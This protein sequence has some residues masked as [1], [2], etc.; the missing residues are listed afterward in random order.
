[1]ATE[2]T[3]PQARR[4]RLGLV[5]AGKHGL[6][7]ARHIVEDVPE[8]R[9][10]GL[11]RRDRVEGER[12]AATY[13]CAW[14]DDFRRLVSDPGVDAIVVAVPPTLHAQVVEAACQAGKPLLIEKPLAVN[15]A[16]AR[17]IRDLVA[18]HGVRCMVAHTLRF[19]AVV[20]VLRAHLAEITPLQT[21]SLSQRF[22]PSSLGWLDRRA[23]AGGGIVLHTGVHS[24]DL[25]RYLTGLEVERVWGLLERRFTRET[26]DAFTL[27]YTMREVPVRGVVAGSR[28]TLG[29]S[30]LIELVGQRGQLVGDHVHG[31]AY[32]LRGRDRLDLPVG[33][34]VPT[35]RETVRAFVTALDEGTPFPI[36]LDDGL[37][38]VAVAEACYRS[39]ARHEIVAVEV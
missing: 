37:R 16:D 18:T 15:L 33:P 8:A 12:A 11:C 38:A 30:G 1:M 9:L 26:E 23:E 22:E 17:R 29:R 35:V 3:T 2:R 5:G 34:T 28:T 14:V 32:L 7:Y 13:G 24:F 4:L 6:R 19:N 21:A 39:A 27:V 10:V 20:G 31:F 36:T 25:L